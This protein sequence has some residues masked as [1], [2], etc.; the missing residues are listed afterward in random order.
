MWKN[1]N[2]SELCWDLTCWVM[3][4]PQIH[5][6]KNERTILQTLQWHL[7]AECKSYTAVFWTKPFFCPMCST[8]Q[9]HYNTSEIQPIKQHTVDGFALNVLKCVSTFQQGPHIFHFC[10]IDMWGF[11]KIFTARPVE[12]DLLVTADI[13]HV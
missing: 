13:S 2:T 5:S 12:K 3:L 9:Y 4:F 7:C 11:I 1:V 10:A 6:R 8:F